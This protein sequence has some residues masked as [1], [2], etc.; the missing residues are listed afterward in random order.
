[1]PIWEYI[2][3]MARL[4]TTADAFSAVAEP[5]RRAIIDL[6]A[7]RGALAVGAIVAALGLPQPSVS[8]HL[9]VLREVGLVS[10]ERVGQQRV[11]RLQPEGLRTMHDW[12]SMFEAMWTHQLDRI[13]Q[14][15]ERMQREA[16]A[17]Q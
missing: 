3:V 1:M 5:L 17:N 12:L 15:A 7:R 6:L 13:Q 2:G 4:A 8:K 11:Y 10:V 14:R 16:K 9:G